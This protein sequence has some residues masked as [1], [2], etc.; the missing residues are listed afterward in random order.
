MI[1]QKTDYECT[2]C[3]K[4][5]SARACSKAYN[6]LITLLSLFS[7]TKGDLRDHLAV[8]VFVYPPN[9]ARQWFGNDTATNTY[10]ITQQL[11]DAVFSRRSVSDH[12]SRRREDPSPK[13]VK[14]LERT[15]MWSWVLK[16][17]ETKTDCASEDQQ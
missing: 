11:L 3:L 9:V 13:H 2:K 17:P 14:V 10:A 16:G 6:Q 7:N 5:V 1:K 8:C 12:S 15:K 4:M